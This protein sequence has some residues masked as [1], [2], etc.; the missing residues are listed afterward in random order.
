MRRGKTQTVDGI[1]FDSAPE[2]ARYLYLRDLQRKGQIRQ[3][4]A[5]P[6]F[7]CRVRDGEGVEHH[8]CYYTPDF[9]YLDVNGAFRCEDVKGFRKSK[10]TGKP[11][12]RVNREFGM[13]RKLMKILFGIEVEIVG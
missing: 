1:C 11:L 13:K 6:R 10:K 8:V 9:T 12:P 2:A 5:H 3:L 4:Q 7:D